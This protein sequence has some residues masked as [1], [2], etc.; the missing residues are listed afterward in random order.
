M[1]IEFHIENVI[2]ENKKIYKRE[3]L[4]SSSA[5]NK[6][7][8]AINKYI[9]F[10]SVGHPNPNKIPDKILHIKKNIILLFFLFDISIIN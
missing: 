7:T 10:P 4:E 1:A 3:R 8:K 6:G 9:G 2:K 5:Y